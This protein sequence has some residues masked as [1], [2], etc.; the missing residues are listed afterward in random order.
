ML[1]PEDIQFYLLLEE[2]IMILISKSSQR[3]TAFFQKKISCNSPSHC[4]HSFFLYN[5]VKI[6]V[7]ETVAESFASLSPTP[8]GR[9]CN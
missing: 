8:Q 9:G 1:L 6:V 4:A 2:Y 3:F 5:T 7:Q